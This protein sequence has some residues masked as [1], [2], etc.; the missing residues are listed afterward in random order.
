VSGLDIDGLDSGTGSRAGDANCAQWMDD[1]VSPL[2]PAITGVDNAGAGLRCVADWL[3]LD[4]DIEEVFDEASRSGDIRWAVRVGEPRA[5][6]PGLVLL[7]VYAVES[8]D[9]IELDEEGYPA[10][11]QVLRARRVG[12]TIAA[13]SDRVAFGI[14]EVPSTGALAQ[15]PE[16]SWLPLDELRLEGVSVAMSEDA[17]SI[18]G[19]LAASFSSASLADRVVEIAPEVSELAREFFESIADLDPRPT[20]PYVCD[21][22]SLGLSFEAVPVEL[23]TE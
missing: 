11:D 12:Q 22:L 5:D 13:I 20:D 15:P 8:G 6:A 7:E 23:L 21:R 4:V 10:P 3:R 16:G 18:E 14:F 1:F 19:E 17:T 2:D 9:P